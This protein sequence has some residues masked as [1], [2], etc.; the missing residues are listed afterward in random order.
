MSQYKRLQIMSASEAAKYLGVHTITIY[1]L[2][3]DTDIPAFKLKGQWRFKRDLL[4]HWV[5][6]RIKRRQQLK[7]K[8]RQKDL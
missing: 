6:K 2:I 5:E 4:E 7:R 8:N 3:Q 1:R